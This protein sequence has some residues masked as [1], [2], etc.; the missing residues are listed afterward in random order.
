MGIGM[1]IGISGLANGLAISGDEG[2]AALA[3]SLL[4]STVDT[5]LWPTWKYGYDDSRP[6]DAT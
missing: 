1:G 3:L 5:T 6:D 2:L 4:G